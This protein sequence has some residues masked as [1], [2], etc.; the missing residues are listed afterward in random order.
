M[1]PNEDQLSQRRRE[2]LAAAESAFDARGYAFTTMEQVAA[3]ARI[4]KGSI[5]NYF[6][7]KHDLFVQVFSEVVSDAEAGTAKLLSEP[8]TA[9]ETL[10][11]LL[12]DWFERLGHYRKIGRLVLEFWATAAREKQDGDLASW[13]GQMYT[14]WRDQIAGVITRGIEAGEFRTG[15]DASVVAAM[16]VAVMDGITVRAILEPSF[17]VDERFLTAAKEAI[18]FTLANPTAVEGR[19][20]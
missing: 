13:F 3:E 1:S 19:Q 20:S 18:L 8:L 11:R 14:R 17:Q 7:N 6:E 16:I 10:Q 5:Y 15:P 2:I 12:D 9:R 4:S